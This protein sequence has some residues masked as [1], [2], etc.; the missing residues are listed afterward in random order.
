MEDAGEKKSR[1]ENSG[2]VSKGMGEDKEKKSG[3][4]KKESKNKEDE[5]RN[6][7]NQTNKKDVSLKTKKSD[8]KK[9][10]YAQDWVSRIPVMY[11]LG[12]TPKD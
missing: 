7:Y 5:K 9:N 10:Y 2:E 3:R 8:R 6:Q 4:K 1:G 12:Q 11:H